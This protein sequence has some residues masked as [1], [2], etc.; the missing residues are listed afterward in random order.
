MGS[1][2]V[3][4]LCGACAV[5]WGAGLQDHPIAAD[6]V[7]Y[8]NGNDWTA[9]AAGVGTIRATVP[10]DLITDLFTAGAIGDPLF[11][12]NFKNSTLW[13]QHTW[14]YQKSFTAAAP[15]GLGAR[16]GRWLKGGGCIGTARPQDPPPRPPHPRR[17]C[18][19]GV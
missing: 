10:G 7:V 13:D 16:E 11:E 17:R 2:S 15:A 12:N 5:A 14:V 8:L 19:V 9:T 1:F 6:S 3:L 4:L 18:A